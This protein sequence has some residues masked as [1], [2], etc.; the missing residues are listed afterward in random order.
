MTTSRP[1]ASLPVTHEIRRLH[2][3]SVISSHCSRDCALAAF[4]QLLLAQMMGED[5]PGPLQWVEAHLVDLATGQTGAST[6]GLVPLDGRVPPE[7][8]RWP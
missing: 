2:D 4:E 5:P 8:L 1:R 7:V 3:G 6:R